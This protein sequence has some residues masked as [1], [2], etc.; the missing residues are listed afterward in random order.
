LSPQSEDIKWNKTA[1]KKKP[2]KC[3]KFK[4]NTVSVG[5]S[6]W[7]CSSVVF[8]S[9]IGRGKKKSLETGL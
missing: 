6:A 1:Q 9:K 7:R 3:P 4:Y 8:S 5:F 2:M